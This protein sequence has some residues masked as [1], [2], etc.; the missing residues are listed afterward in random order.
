MVHIFHLS[1]EGQGGS[2][3]ETD[4]KKVSGLLILFVA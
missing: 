4:L 1:A 2:V 3:L